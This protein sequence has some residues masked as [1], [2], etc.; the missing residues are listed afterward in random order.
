MSYKELK[1]TLEKEF[2]DLKLK[3]HVDFENPIP[4]IEGGLRAEWFYPLLKVKIDLDIKSKRLTKVIGYMQ[5][6]ELFPSQIDE[7]ARKLIKKLT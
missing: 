7:V 3:V 5:E 4:V 1:T 6:G 2:K